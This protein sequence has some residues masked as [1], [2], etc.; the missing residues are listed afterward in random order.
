MPLYEY[1]CGECGHVVEV[2]ERAADRRKHTCPKCGCREMEKLVSAFGVG[3]GKRSSSPS[4][5]T[6]TCPFS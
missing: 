3:A 2:L 1:R 4:C 6:G 5:P